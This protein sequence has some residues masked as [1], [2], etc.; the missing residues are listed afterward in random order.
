MPLL[1]V[2]DV[3]SVIGTPSAEADVGF[4]MDAWSR[5]HAGT[6]AGPGE[7]RVALWL[8]SGVGRNPE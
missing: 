5:R 3:N 4:G 7:E 1:S 2:Y 6:G 8:L